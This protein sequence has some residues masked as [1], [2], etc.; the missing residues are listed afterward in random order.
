MDENLDDPTRLEFYPKPDSFEDE[1]RW[2]MMQ[3]LHRCDTSLDPDISALYLR[4]GTGFYG[5]G[6]VW[7]NIACG[8]VRPSF[9]V[10]ALLR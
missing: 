9:I 3:A 1:G 4:C 5:A 6:T 2:I 10:A 7:E 8:E